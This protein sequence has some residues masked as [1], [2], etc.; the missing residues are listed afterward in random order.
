M[1]NLNAMGLGTTRARVL[2]SPRLFTAIRE[3]PRST[4]SNLA[5]RADDRMQNTPANAITRGE[6]VFVA[7]RRAKGAR[8]PVYHAV[9][10]H[11]RMALC[12]I[13]PGAGSG[14]AEPP[15]EKVTC[16]PCLQRL[17]RL[18]HP[19]IS[20]RIDSASA[21]PESRNLRGHMTDR[22]SGPQPLTPILAPI[23]DSVPALPAVIPAAK[24]RGSNAEDMASRRGSLPP[25][26]AGIP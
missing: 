18:S 20:S 23:L 5:D 9:T 21:L 11:C 15:A 17:A 7:L 12:A 2:A 8:S 16:T 25:T 10:P 24:A 13:E 1:R 6:R 4:R 19:T 22:P 26:L 14:W 3:F